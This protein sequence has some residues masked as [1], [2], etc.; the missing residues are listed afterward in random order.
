MALNPNL[1]NMQQ[2][3][4]NIALSGQSNG[5]VISATVK[6]DEATAL[7]PG[8]AVKLVDIAGGQIIVT[9][10]TANTDKPFGFVFGNIKDVAFAANDRVEIACQ[11]SVMVMTAGAAIARGALLEVVYTTKKVIT[12]AGTNPV[13]GFT[14]DKAAADGD[15]VRVLITP[16]LFRGV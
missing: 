7:I 10:T 16:P 8:Q 15:L 6:S 13:C 1:F 4:G 14:L 5:V 2:E 9:A 12:N 3:Q 11:N